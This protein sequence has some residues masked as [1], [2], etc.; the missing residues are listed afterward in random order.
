MSNYGVLPFRVN[1][2]LK[3]QCIIWLDSTVNSLKENTEAQRQLRTLTNNL[4]IFEDEQLCLQHL[5][6]VRTDERI[7]LIVS[8]RL[9]RII[10]PKI[11]HQPQI[12][13]IYVYCRDK[14]VNEE[15]TKR[16]SKV[17]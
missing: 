1:K 17:S 7:I 4:L 15:W 16:I 9:G 6:A 12:I 13:S 3:L 14:Q 8:G 5:Y 2:H 10:V 11:V